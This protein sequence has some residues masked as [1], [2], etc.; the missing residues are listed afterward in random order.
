[1]E[2]GKILFW[3]QYLFFTS[4]LFYADIYL[5]KF[6]NANTIQCVFFNVNT[7]DTTGTDTNDGTDLVLVALLSILNKFHTFFWYFHYYFEQSNIWLATDY[8]NKI[9]NM[10][11]PYQCDLHK[12]INLIAYR[13]FTEGD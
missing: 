13:T 11:L 9:I 1:M 6:N 8:H 12:W 10:Y 3:M 4:V 7:N 5:F 2:L